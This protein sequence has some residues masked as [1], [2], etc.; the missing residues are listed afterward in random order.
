MYFKCK[1]KKSGTYKENIIKN[2]RIIYDSTYMPN[3]F[4]HLYRDEIYQWILFGNEGRNKA[5]IADSWETNLSGRNGSVLPMH[6][7]SH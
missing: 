5:S 2:I 3:F 7:M 6:H 4:S 1:E